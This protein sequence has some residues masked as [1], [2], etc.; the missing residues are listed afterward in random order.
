[1]EPWYRLNN[2]P[3][4]EY[5]TNF[6]FFIKHQIF[7]SKSGNEYSYCSFLESKL[8]LFERAIFNG[9]TFTDEHKMEA[10]RRI[11]KEILEGKH[12]AGTL[13]D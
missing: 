9:Y 13:V 10:A 2:K 3:S 8:F 5:S 7:V 1:M 6:N 4:V 11:H 12:G